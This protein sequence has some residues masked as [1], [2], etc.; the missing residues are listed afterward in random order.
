M[1]NSTVLENLVVVKRSGQR[2]SFN[3]VKIAVAIKQAFDSSDEN[4]INNEKKIN[5]VYNQVL[6]FI[7][8]SYENRKTINVEDIQD[9]IENVLKKTGYHDV[10]K[11]FNEYRLRRAASREAFS[12][13]EQHKFVKAIEKIGLTAKNSKNANPD[14]LLLNFGKTISQEF[15][16]AYLLESKYVRAHEEGRIYID[17]LKSYALKTTSSS[18]LDFSS[19]ESNDIDEITLKILNIVNRFKS[20]QYGEQTISNLDQIYKNVMISDFNNK[21]LDNL[22]CFFKVLGIYEFFDFN[23]LKN[24][25]VENNTIKINIDAFDAILPNEKI[26]NYFWD[27]YRITNDYIEAKLLKN[28]EL[29]LKNFNSNY[30]KYSDTSLSISLSEIDDFE[31]MYF[32]EKYFEILNKISFKKIATICKVKK[33]TSLDYIIDEVYNKN[34]VIILYLDNNEYDDYLETFS[35]Q[36]IINE[37]VNNDLQTSRG[38]ILNSSITI[39]LARLGLKY[40][41]ESI[42]DFFAELDDLLELSKNELI[43]RYDFQSSLY[44][45]NFNGIFENNILFD[46]K[47]LDCNQKV[48]KV[49]K[50]GVLCINFSGLVECLDALFDVSEKAAVKLDFGLKIVE[51]MKEKINKYKSD[52][53]LNFILAEESSKIVNKNLLALDKAMV[54]N[55][56]IL[57][58]DF[59]SSLSSLFNDLSNKALYQYIVKYQKNCSLNLVLNVDRNKTKIKD[60][61]KELEKEKVKVVKVVV[62]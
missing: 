17:D 56:E 18:H 62:K 24:V 9:I 10:Y 1:E 61:I 12:V 14:D 3:S 26:K 55:I 23:D 43:Q 8:E 41:K 44:K 25:L 49:L 6:K 29:L 42:N 54:G 19:I 47:K 36:I 20:E 13:K 57:K 45:E 32:K 35:N 28:I 58:K 11:K 46:S 2:V 16:K 50:N 7:V 39:N 51:F 53:K 5:R 27:I 38:R 48:R 40:N 34:N 33:N 15:A 30:L 31:S 59:Y 52:L 22:K 60:Y 21:F 37:N 4:E